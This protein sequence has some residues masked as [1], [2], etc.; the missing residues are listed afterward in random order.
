MKLSVSATKGKTIIVTI[1]EAGEV[2]GLAAAVSGKP[3]EMPAETI[4]PRQVKFVKCDDFLQFI[5]DDAEA[6]LKVA[7]QLSEQYYDACKEVRSLELSHSAVE[8]LI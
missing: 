2:L 6:C 5:K 4:D 8:K 7:E 3:Y 1:A